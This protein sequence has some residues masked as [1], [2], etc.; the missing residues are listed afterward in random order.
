MKYTLQNNKLKIVVKEVGAEL[1]QISSVQNVNEFMWDANPNVWANHAP[2]LFPIIG[3]LK[4]D[5]FTFDGKTYNL[6]KHGFIRYNEDIK[7]YE[8]TKESLTFKLKYNESALKSYP[9]KFEFSITYTLKD[10]IVEINHTVKNLDTKTMYFSVGGHPAFA[11]PIYDDDSY[12]DYFLEFERIEN[13]KRHLINM[14]SGLISSN[15]QPVF[16][17]SNKI[18]LT[19]DLFQ[20]DALIFKDLKSRKVTLKSDTYGAILTLNFKDFPYL[21]I[22][23]KPAGDF[24]CIEPW[25]GIAD[26]ENTNQDLKTKEGILSLAAGET[27]SAAYSIEIHNNHLV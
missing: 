20:K 10:N 21:G 14:D 19:H 4:N 25:Q 18:R 9:F 12:N 23:A 16:A 15:T 8:Q 11:C 1:C 26:H 13:S 22:W 7:L 24:I 3:A 5:S 17:D 2:N 27:F 6:V